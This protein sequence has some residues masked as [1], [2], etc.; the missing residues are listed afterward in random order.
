LR[1]NR[2]YGVL[3][4]A[5]RSSVYMRQNDNDDSEMLRRYA[6]HINLVSYVI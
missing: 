5:S 3:G 1:V 6:D 2:T 4:K